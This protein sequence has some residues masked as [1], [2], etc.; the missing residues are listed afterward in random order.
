MSYIDDIKKKTT[1]PSPQDWKN[2]KMKQFM[3]VLATR[4]NYVTRNIEGAKSILPMA[5]EAISDLLVAQ[6]EE[7]KKKLEDTAKVFDEGKEKFLASLERIADDAVRF[8]NGLPNSAEIKSEHIERFLSSIKD[9]A[10]SLDSSQPTT[11]Q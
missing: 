8:I 6:S 7:M 3:S 10:N 11:D 4:D 9:E 1:T 5:Q 2:D